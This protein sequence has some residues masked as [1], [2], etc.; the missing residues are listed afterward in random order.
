MMRLRDI[1]MANPH[2]VPCPNGQHDPIIDMYSELLE[3]SDQVAVA[4][5]QAAMVCPAC[6]E[7]MYWPLTFL[8]DPAS[9]PVGMPV[10]YWSL[11]RW[12]RWAPDD[13]QTALSRVPNL[14]RFLR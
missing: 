10:V 12:N 6:G 3:P 14:M 1:L 11:A 7:K 8:K 4:N 13:Q 9:A 2:F 5:G